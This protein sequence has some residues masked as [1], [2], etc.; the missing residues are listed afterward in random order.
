MRDN[1]EKSIENSFLNLGLKVQAKN[2]SDTKVVSQPTSGSLFDSLVKS[3]INNNKTEIL[4]SI[5]NS[6]QS[7]HKQEEKIGVV[8]TSL[9]DQLIQ[10]AKKEIGQESKKEEVE[11]KDISKEDIK[12]LINKEEKIIEIKKESVDIKVKEESKDNIVDGEINSLEAVKKEENKEIVK[13]EVNLKEE[14]KN[15]EVDK[16][17]SE[18]VV[19]V[20]DKIEVNNSKEKENNLNKSLL[21][22]LI[23]V[24]K[25]E[26]GQESKKEEVELKDISKEDIKGLINKE[27]KIIEIKKESVDIKVKEESKDN[28]VDG[29]I[30]SLEAVK[31]EENKEIVKSEVNLKEEIKNKEVDKLNSEEVVIV[32]DKIEVNNS[33]EKENNLNKSLLDQLV[34]KNRVDYLN[35]SNIAY[36]DFKNEDLITN[37]YLN[38]QRNQMNNQAL[39]TKKEA[40]NLLLN[41]SNIND[42]QKSA[43]LLELG[44]ENLDI[45]KVVENIKKLD[46][47]NVD[48]RNLIDTLA[49]NK[50][51]LNI[52]LKDMIT[53]SIEA[54]K[55]LLE[56]T[57]N[58]I[59][60][61]T[62]NANPTQTQMIETRIVAARQNINHMMSDLAR[63]MYENYK[64]PVTAFRINLNPATLGAISILMKNDRE[65][66]LV[67][68]MA[69]SNST[70]LESLKENQ[71]ILK[72]SL[73]SSFN[74][75]MN[76]DLDFNSSNSNSSNNKEEK[77]T[78]GFDN[79]LSTKDILGMKEDNL[80]QESKNLDYM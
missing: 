60:D 41:G 67:I 8:K 56:N 57:I 5:K 35:N 25:K 17:N 59:D 74:G 80:S 63:Q 1:M 29:E 68:S 50:N 13:S 31:K 61:I 10:V 48:R 78:E 36:K 51:I 47:N 30:N 52:E 23:Q 65:N 79:K 38:T 7:L 26:I 24:A 6:T 32:E 33:K 21:D 53:S 44:L 46:L 12:G 16:L 9:L 18:E 66:S 70:T 40:V 76:I 69:V 28:I 15:K 19:I 20:E 11:L 42:I 71:N 72:S 22:Q 3:T 43:E 54:S 73:I 37:I 14:I 77:N 39:A 64:P 4:D 62:L 49:F 55:A 2:T 75:E 45:E 34:Q 58:V 27:E